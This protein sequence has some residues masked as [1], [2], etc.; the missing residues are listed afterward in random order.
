MNLIHIGLLPLYIKLYDDVDPALR[1]LQM[2]FLKDVE[3]ALQS[4]GLI[5]TVS[6]VCRVHG[7]FA[8]AVEEF[9]KLDV[10]A[11]VTLHLAYSPSLEAIDALAALNAPIILMDTTPTFDFTATAGLQAIDRNHGIHGVQDLCCML[12]RRDIPY[13]L[14]CGHLDSS[15]I[16]QRV[17]GLCRAAAAATAMKRMR[18]GLV[19]EP[20]EGM[21]DFRV[22]PK[23][24]EAVTGA[25]VVRLLPE[26]AFAISECITKADVE[27]QIAEDVSQYDSEVSNPESHYLATRAALTLRRW[28]KKNALGALSVNFS[29][30]T[31]AT[32]LDKMPFGELSRMMARGIGYAGEG[33]VLTASMVGAL[34]TVY[35]S[36]GF[37]EMFCPDWKRG[38]LLIS[39][40]AEMNI[41]LSGSKPLLT[42]VPFPF[43]DV[44]DTVGAFA[45]H[46]AGAAVLVNLAPLRPDRFT[47]L[48]AQVDMVTPEWDETQLRNQIRGWLKPRIALDRFLTWFSQ[49]GGTHHSAL[50]YDADIATLSAF[51]HMM[52]FEVVIADN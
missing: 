37:V 42:D 19:G 26:D 22:D 11:V 4:E 43:T 29:Q 47:L 24:L 12:K 27:A 15:D 7:E 1:D 35:E 30:V 5:V 50:V 41:A 28:V 21:G 9:N 18:V 36:T 52:G 44:G 10:A 48:L 13:H 51:G 33:D 39:H 14:V 6:D 49:A 16:A 40:M 31:R 23:T 38:I 46:R 20:F 2:P 3:K 8:H 32:G 45:C 25:Q 17:A 34:M